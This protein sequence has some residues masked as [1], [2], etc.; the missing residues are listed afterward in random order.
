MTVMKFCKKCGTFMKLNNIGYSC[1]KCG[2][3]E[4]I[5]QI[6]V[7]MEEKKE[8]KT[9]Y[10]VDERRKDSCK[11]NRTCPHCGFNEAYRIVLATQGEHAGVKQDRSLVKYTCTK[12]GHVWTS[13]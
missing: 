5:D 2:T 12:C 9:V 1:L 7:N 6:E 8:L 13:D 3:V 11:V 4:Y 10:I